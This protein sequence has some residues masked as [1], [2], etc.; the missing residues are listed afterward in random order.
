MAFVSC[1]F[2]WPGFD[3]DYVSIDLMHCGCLGV[4]L[5]LLGSVIWERFHSMKGKVTKPQVTSSDICRCSKIAA[6]AI[7]QARPPTND[8]VIGMLSSDSKQARPRLKVK[9]AE[10]RHLLSCV[11]RLLQNVGS[12]FRI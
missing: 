8:L 5:Y 4:N 12:K 11:S 3:I 1:I 7:G 2:S 6:K 9:A 10:S